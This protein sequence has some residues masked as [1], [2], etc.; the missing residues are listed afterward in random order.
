MAPEQFRNAKN[1]DVK[2]DVYSVGATLYMMVT[3][4]LPFGKSSGPLDAWM[5][6]INNDLAAPRQLVPELSERID[7]AIRRAMSPDPNQRPA[8]CREF[9]EDLT[10]QSTRKVN[11]PADQSGRLTDL[12]YLVYK[13]DTGATHTVKGST[14]GI[15]RSL[16][17]RLLGDASNV[18]AARTKSGPFES[19]KGY[20]EFRDLLVM[21][22]SLPPQ[23]MPA[24][25][26]P[27]GSASSWTNKG[28]QTTPEA[29]PVGPAPHIRLEPAQTMPAWVVM[30]AMFVIAASTALGALY[31]FYWR[32]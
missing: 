31:I 26:A 3:G 11:T 6:K 17:E 9:V 24:G 16:R 10:G 4:D 7:W 1:A 20:P 18:R 22:G 5:K 8:S 12:W 15:R 28:N 13:D 30:A 32:K 23:A 2:C 29:V 14:E 27:P 19:L 21:P 25:S